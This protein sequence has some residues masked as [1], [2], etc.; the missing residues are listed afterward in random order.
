M[1][2]QLG[3]PYVWGGT[4]PDGWDCSGLMMMAY[5]AAGISIP[6]GSIAQSTIGQPIY[7]TNQLQPGDLLFVPGLDGTV[8]APGHVG[9]YLGQ[10]MLVEAPQSGSRVQ[11]SPLEGYWKQNLVSIRRKV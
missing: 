1:L 3:K 8:T 9:M 11:L 2:A 5:R 10:G 7:D 6:R 4:G